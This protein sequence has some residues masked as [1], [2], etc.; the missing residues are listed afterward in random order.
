MRR[1]LIRSILFQSP[2]RNLRVQADFLTD[3]KPLKSFLSSQEVP[4]EIGDLSDVVFINRRL[5]TLL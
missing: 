2:L 1:D 4:F 3:V 5:G